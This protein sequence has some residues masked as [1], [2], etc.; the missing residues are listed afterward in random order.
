VRVVHESLNPTEVVWVS[1]G[2]MSLLINEANRTIPAETGGVLLGYWAQKGGEPVITNAIGPGPR[3]V[4]E[5][6][7]FV[8]D[9]DYH[10][11]QIGGL[12]EASGRRL[13]YLGDWHTH[14]GGTASPSK[15]DLATLSLIASTKNARL[16]TPLMLILAP[17]PN[18]NP[19]AWLAEFT[20]SIARQRK[21][22]LHRLRIQLFQ[23]A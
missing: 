9:Q 11:E 23:Q 21:L 18:W 7:R 16:P 13:R 4:H 5:C 22:I 17:G 1:S 8:P 12:Y 14:P 19:S 10:L 6:R 3:A 20:S 15:S 2:V